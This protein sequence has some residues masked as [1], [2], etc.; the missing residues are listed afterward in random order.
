MKIMD[1]NPLIQLD[2]YAKNVTNAEKASKKEAHEAGQSGRRDQVILSP[3]AKAIQEAKKLL[4]SLPD[5]RED[6]V[7]QIKEQIRNGTYK[8]D[9][10]KVAAKM[11]E[12]SLL[13]D[14]L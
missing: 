11:V 4:E 6:R 5:V 8:I 14:L 12:E 1:K 9:A 10:K 2:A 13:N 3:K 7:A